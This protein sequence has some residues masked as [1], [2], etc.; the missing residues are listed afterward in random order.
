MGF[1]PTRAEH[2]GL[3]VQRLNLSAKSSSRGEPPENDFKIS[4]I[5]KDLPTIKLSS[6]AKVCYFDI[7][8]AVEKNILQFEVTMNQIVFLKK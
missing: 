2:I 3:A 4:R 5:V 7:K 6:E 8:V 1:E